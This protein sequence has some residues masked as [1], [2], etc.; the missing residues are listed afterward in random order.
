MGEVVTWTTALWRGVAVFAYF[1]IT[2]VW[3]PDVVISLSA[4][5][6]APGLVRDLIVLIVWGVALGAGMYLLRRAQQRALI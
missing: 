5:S 1:T 2:T 3:L 6:D 4:V